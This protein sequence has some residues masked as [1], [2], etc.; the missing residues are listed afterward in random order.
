[1]FIGEQLFVVCGSGSDRGQ[2]GH[3]DPTEQ[4][5]VQSSWFVKVKGAPLPL[6]N[7]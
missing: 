5:R 6:H 3:S 7:M 2:T 1:M 4:V